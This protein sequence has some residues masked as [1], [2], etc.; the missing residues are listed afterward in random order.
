M[1][2]EEV[3]SVIMDHLGV[4]EQK[5]GLRHACESRSIIEEAV[6]RL[7]KAPESWEELRSALK[8]LARD[9]RQMQAGQSLN[10]IH[11]VTPVGVCLD[12]GLPFPRLE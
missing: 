5:A 11:V 7:G 2:N 3:I 12:R 6:K 10:L 9:N 8:L 1:K 4:S